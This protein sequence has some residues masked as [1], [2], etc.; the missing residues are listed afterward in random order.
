MN[1]CKFN[2]IWKQFSTINYVERANM[3]LSALTKLLDLIHSI[4]SDMKREREREMGLHQSYFLY[5]Q[6][7]WIADQYIFLLKNNGSIPRFH[8][9]ACI[10]FWS[11]ILEGACLQ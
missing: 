1:L 9:L 4:C 3:F 11:D 10:K 6:K 5:K 2:Y 8:D 7:S